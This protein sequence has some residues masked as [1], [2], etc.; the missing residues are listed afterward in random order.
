MIIRE[1][2]VTDYEIIY[3]V[4]KKAFD[5]AEHTDGNEPKRDCILS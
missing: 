1:E 5:S 3:S 2:K 4:V